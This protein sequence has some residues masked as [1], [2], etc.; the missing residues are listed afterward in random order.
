MVMPGAIGLGGVGGKLGTLKNVM[1]PSPIL[2]MEFPEVCVRVCVC[3]SANGHLLGREGGEGC[4]S[5]TVMRK[6]WW[7]EGGIV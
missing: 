1:T 5:R 7:K 2:Y 4:F 3:V 6:M